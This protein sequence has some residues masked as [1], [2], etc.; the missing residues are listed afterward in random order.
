M[1]SLCTTMNSKTIAVFAL[2]KPKT[3]YRPKLKKTCL[4]CDLMAA[5]ARHP[6]TLHIWSQ[7]SQS[8]WFQ[9]G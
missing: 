6:K 5:E 1:K 2:S 8:T 9:G 7:N 4:T 3:R